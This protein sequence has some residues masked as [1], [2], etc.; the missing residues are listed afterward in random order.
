MKKRILVLTFADHLTDA[1]VQA[2]TQTHKNATGLYSGAVL[3]S[4]Y[5]PCSDHVIL[6]KGGGK[7][8]TTELLRDLITD[9]PVY[10]SDTHKSRSFEK[11]GTHYVNDIATE[12]N[13]SESDPVT[14][15]S[16]HFEPEVW[17]KIVKNY[18]PFYPA[19]SGL[20]LKQA[21][22]TEQNPSLFILMAF[23]WLNSPENEDY[24]ENVYKSL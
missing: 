13:P 4:A 24:W 8:I 15:M 10:E 16:K 21:C 22:K 2:I 9:E 17:E 6:P 12:F 18:D 7:S 20:S 1:Q 11:D 3:K 19:G 23:H 14:E 5:M